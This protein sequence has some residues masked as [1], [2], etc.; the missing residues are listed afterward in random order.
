MVAQVL[1][2]IQLNY[3]GQERVRAIGAY[4]MALA[5]ALTGAVLLAIV[6]LILGPEQ[7]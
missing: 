7:H 2:G 3:S 5:A 6:P 1:R 4:A